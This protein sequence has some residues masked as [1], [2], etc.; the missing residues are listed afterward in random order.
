VYSLFEPLRASFVLHTLVLLVATGALF[1]IVRRI[2]GIHNAIAGVI[3]FAFYLPVVRGLGTDYVE[4]AVLMY[5]LVSSALMQKAGYAGSRLA[6]FASGFA[7][8]AMFHSNIGS[9][10]LFPSI[11]IWAVPATRASHAWRGMVSRISVWAFGIVACTL[12][13]S[14]ASAA[15]GGRWL[16]FVP[17]VTWLAGVGT[18]NPWDRTGLAWILEAPWV[19]LPVA[20]MLCIA[21]AALVRRPVKIDE[22]RLR[23]VG[24]LVV[25]FLVFAAWDSVGPGASLY[26]PFY[27]SW[28]IPP[29][30]VVLA[31]VGIGSLPSGSVVTVTSV[32][33][34][35]LL[36]LT[37][38]FPDLARVPMPFYGSVLVVLTLAILAALT[39]RAGVA[40]LIL[41]VMVAFLNT[42]V[43]TMPFYA[44]RD[45]RIDTFH[46]VT[47]AVTIADRYIEHSRPLVVLERN[48]KMV[49]YFNSFTSAYLY[50]YVLVS[51]TYPEPAKTPAQPIYDGAL[52]IIVSTHEHEEQRLGPYFAAHGMTGR[53]L[54][55][56]R[57]DTAI[58]PYTL[59]FVRAVKK[60]SAAPEAALGGAISQSVKR[61]G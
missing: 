35:L 6:A 10:F 31:A 20:T 15:T 23:A 32:T 5:G 50:G 8:G 28:L 38:G 33:A 4:A 26:W 34:G 43:A 7:A 9:V 14:A 22:A 47:R 40:T 55:H 3:L 36:L 17:S 41:A 48:P 45:N 37:A 58:G 1:V 52:V 11:L 30:M 57:V 53:V 60:P 49:A 46:A 27:S 2:A 51:G 24:A 25:T 19:F 18:K 29:S 56:D 61:A 13:L 21:I 39:R 16:F 44:P 12:V 42:W 59:T 54:G